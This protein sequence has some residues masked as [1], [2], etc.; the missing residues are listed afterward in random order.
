MELATVK[1]NLKVK[2]HI[3]ILISPKS[4][5]FDLQASWCDIFTRG[6]QPN[7]EY[8]DR[9]LCADFLICS[10]CAIARLNVENPHINRN[11]H[12]IRQKIILVIMKTKLS[13]YVTL[14]KSRHGYETAVEVEADGNATIPF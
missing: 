11:L 10:E 12:I 14:L 8:F 13:V 9:E 7:V 2:S 4:Y 1:Q 5:I 6:V 3:K